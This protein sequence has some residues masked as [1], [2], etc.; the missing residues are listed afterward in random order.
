MELG[1][2]DPA[3]LIELDT[4]IQQPAV[5]LGLTITATILLSVCNFAAAVDDSMPRH[6]TARLELA[7]GHSDVSGV[8]RKPGELCDLPIRGDSSPRNTANHS[9]K[10]AVSFILRHLRRPTKKYSIG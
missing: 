6:P 3:L 8:A 2:R 7:Q 4:F 5:L 1:K 9:V 10:Q